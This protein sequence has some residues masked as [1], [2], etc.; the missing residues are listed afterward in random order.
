MIVPVRESTV[1][2]RFHIKL[3]NFFSES[4]A[5]TRITTCTEQAL[6]ELLQ[7]LPDM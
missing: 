2:A 3:L 5:F 6:S 4:V 1:R 7:R